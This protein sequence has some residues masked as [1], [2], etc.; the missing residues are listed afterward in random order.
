MKDQKLLW[1][2]LVFVALAVV[3]FIF[4]DFTPSGWAHEHKVPQG[5]DE[6]IKGRWMAEEGGKKNV[7][8]KR[9]ELGE[10]TGAMKTCQ[11]PI[12]IPF[13]GAPRS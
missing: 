2:G 11:V 3:G 6:P 1:V 5:H 10:R 12:W 9:R 4:I 13:L 8:N 7:N